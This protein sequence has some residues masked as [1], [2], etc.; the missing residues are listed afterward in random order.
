MTPEMERFFSQPDIQNVIFHPRPD[1][2]PPS[3]ADV[4]LPGVDGIRLGGRLHPAATTT[5]PLILFFH[6]NGEI[7]S[8]Y[9]DIAPLYNRIGL[10]FLVVDYRGYGRSAGRPSVG[11]LAADAEAVHAALPG[12]FNDHGLTPS[13]QFVMGRSLGSA[14]AIAIAATT[15]PDLDGLIIESGFAYELELIARLGG[16]DLRH[17]AGL[18][19]GFG[20]LARIARVT[21]PLLIIHGEADFMIPMRD[22]E[23]LLQQAGSRNKRLLRI[24]A[25]GHNDLLMQGLPAYFQAIREFTQSA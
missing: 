23:A 21:L 14:A 19:E 13:R 17:V 15:P 6:G 12:L 3:K 25:G 11:T 1:P 4:V 10:S 5:A 16:P 2:A 20:S 8:D 7:A 18:Q 22:A 24:P 9:D